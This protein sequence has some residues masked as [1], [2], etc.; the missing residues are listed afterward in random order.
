MYQAWFASVVS[1]LLRPNI[2]ILQ[3]IQITGPCTYRAFLT[4]SF[5]PHLQK[6]DSNGGD[7]GCQF[8]WAVKTVCAIHR[9]WYGDR[10][11]G[12]NNGVGGGGNERRGGCRA[13]RRAWCTGHGQG[14]GD[15]D[16]GGGNGHFR[17]VDGRRG[18]RNVRGR[19]G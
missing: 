11:V 19:N 5:H 7:G 8:N 13:V 6:K 15:R 17:L 16:A 12:R 4:C 2:Q 1:P 14:V 10:P 3:T 9:W 18:F